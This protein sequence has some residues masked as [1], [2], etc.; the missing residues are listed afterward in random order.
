MYLPPKLT[1]MIAFVEPRTTLFNIYKK[2][3]IFLI[4]YI[5]IYHMQ[6][7]NVRMLFLRKLYI[8]FE[9]SNLCHWI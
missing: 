6:N 8:K 2:L 4:I 5:Y 9:I 3:N 7:I 1:Q